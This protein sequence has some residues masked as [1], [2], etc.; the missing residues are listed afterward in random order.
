M[1]LSVPH[2]F[3]GSHQGIADIG[4]DDAGNSPYN[5]V[6]THR[7]DNSPFVNRLYHG[8]YSQQVVTANPSYRHG[9]FQPADIQVQR[10]PYRQS[11]ENILGD[12]LCSFKHGHHGREPAVHIRTISVWLESAPGTGLCRVHLPLFPFRDTAPGTI[13]AGVRPCWRTHNTHPPGFHTFSCDG[14]SHSRR[15]CRV[16]NQSRL[17]PSLSVGDLHHQVLPVRPGTGSGHQMAQ[18]DARNPGFACTGTADVDLDGSADYIRLEY[19]E[20]CSGR[21]LSRADP[22][23]QADSGDR[24]HSERLWRRFL[25]H[26]A[27]ELAHTWRQRA[28]AATRRLPAASLRLALKTQLGLPRRSGVVLPERRSS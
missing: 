3:G 28:G 10:S 20:A 13:E 27:A 11:P 16:S 22:D 6:Q 2:V 17:I 24:G 18:T 8:L 26:D 12:I 7:E 25:A 21:K 5:R 4:T 1:R 23:H 19:L 9:L 15:D 14:G